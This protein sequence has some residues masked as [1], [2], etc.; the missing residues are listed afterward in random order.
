MRFDLDEVVKD[1][2]YHYADYSDMSFAQLND[3]IHYFEID[4]EHLPVDHSV[5][6]VVYPYQEDFEHF[7]FKMAAD[8]FIWLIFMGRKTMRLSIKFFLGLI[9]VISMKG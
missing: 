4:K 6:R 7:N 1:A 2:L 5:Y 3:F 9:Q 8:S